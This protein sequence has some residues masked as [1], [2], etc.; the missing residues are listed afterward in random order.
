VYGLKAAGLDDGAAPDST[1][2][3][4]AARYL[5]AVRTIQPHGPYR[6]CGYCYGGVVAFAMAQQLAGIG[7]TVD[8]LGII[9]GFAPGWRSERGPLWQPQRLRLLVGS[10]PFWWQDY[11]ALRPGAIRR[12]FQRVLRASA[13]PTAQST[14]PASPAGTA[15]EE[16][17]QNWGTGA[18]DTPGCGLAE[19]VVDDDLSMLPTDKRHLLEVHLRA[20]RKFAPLRYSGC[21]TLFRSRRR[22]ITD[23]LV[24][25]LDVD[26]GW[27][28]LAAR[29]TVHEVDGAHRNLHLM[30]HVRSLAAALGAYLVPCEVAPMAPQQAADGGSESCEAA[31]IDVPCTA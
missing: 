8:L 11:R 7:E 30:P 29:I 3:A 15:A 28:R 4:M 25:P 21:I 27:G 26:L 16:G 10:L 24:R 5:V 2:D 13:S 20:I 6:L 18:C 9:E 14:G 19:D 23:V 17:T 12:R 31:A 1:I 22:S